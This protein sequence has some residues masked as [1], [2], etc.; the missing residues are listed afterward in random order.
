MHVEN[1]SQ[2]I[3]YHLDDRKRGKKMEIKLHANATTTPRVR[4][5]IQQSNKSDRALAQELG[6]SVSTVRRWRT[7]QDVVDQCTAPKTTHNVLSFEQSGL[8]N[9]VRQKLMIPLDE[10]LVLVNSGMQQ[11]ISR[12]GLDRY[13][14]RAEVAHMNV[15]AA[16]ELRGKKAIKAGEKLGKLQLFYHRLNLLPEDGG[17]QHILW[18]QEAVSGWIAARAYAGASSS[19]VVHWLESLREN[20]PAGIQSIET[21]NKALFGNALPSEHPL[22]QWSLETGIPVVLREEKTADITL[23]LESPLGAL[24]PALATIDLDS[25]LQSL[26]EQYNQQWPQKK[27]GGMTPATFWTLYR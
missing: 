11:Q 6:I 7:R 12:A 3:G 9:W 5:Y 21:E 17:E 19:L 25:Y 27:L 2:I 23:R 26:C 13:L 20:A 18:A 1:K 16:R 15:L 4:R 8:I 22:Q 24:I 14:R 10:L